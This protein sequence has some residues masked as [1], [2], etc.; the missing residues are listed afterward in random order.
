[1]DNLRERDE[2]FVIQTLESLVTQS[3]SLYWRIKLADMTSSRIMQRILS[4]KFDSIYQDQIASIQVEQG[5]VTPEAQVRLRTL[6]QV[7]SSEFMEERRIACERHLNQVKKELIDSDIEYLVRIYDSDTIFRSLLQQ[8]ATDLEL[9]MA[10]ALREV[11]RS[12]FLAEYQERKNRV[13]IHI[14]TRELVVNE[15]AISSIQAYSEDHLARR[16][17]LV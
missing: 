10:V 17:G 11:T 12:R 9:E 15:Q 5:T 8:V 1:M 2:E 3:F 16:I 14:L 7:F 4:R 6:I 13:Q